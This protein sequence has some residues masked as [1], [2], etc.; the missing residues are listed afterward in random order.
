MARD[1]ISEAVRLEPCHWGAWLELSGHITD[2]NEI[3]HL[4]LPEHWMKH[5]FLAHTYLELQ[6]NEDA[7]GIYFGLQAR[8]LQDS[9]Y[10]LAQVS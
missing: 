5:F 6:L 2:R 4:D 1:V 10:I 7:L 8:G 3:E 9:T